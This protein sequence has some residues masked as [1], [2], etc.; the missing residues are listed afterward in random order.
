VLNVVLD[1]PPQTTTVTGTVTSATGADAPGYK[2]DSNAGTIVFVVVVLV[3]VVGGLLLFLRSRR[4][5]P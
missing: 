5:K 2:S 3:L 4:N 1:I